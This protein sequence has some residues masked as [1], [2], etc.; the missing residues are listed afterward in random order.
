MVNEVSPD[1]HLTDLSISGEEGH[2]TTLLA[3]YISWFNWGQGY[4]ETMVTP[5]NYTKM[6]RNLSF[7]CT[8]CIF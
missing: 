4:L 3:H 5:Q 6:L 7:C 1:S 8:I 2:L